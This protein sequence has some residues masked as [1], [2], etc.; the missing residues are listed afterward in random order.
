MQTGKAGLNTKLRHTGLD[1]ALD[2][3]LQIACLV[4]DGRLEKVVQVLAA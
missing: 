3:I 2:S 1:P 4:T